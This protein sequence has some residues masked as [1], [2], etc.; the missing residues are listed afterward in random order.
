M[1]WTRFPARWAGLG[2]GLARWADPLGDGV[3]RGPGG[4]V[5]AGVGHVHPRFLAP[6]HGAFRRGGT[7]P[8]VVAA[9]DHWRPSGTPTGVGRGGGGGSP[10]ETVAVRAGSA[11]VASADC[12]MVRTSTKRSRSRVPVPRERATLCDADLRAWLKPR[13]AWHQMPAFSELVAELPVTP[14]GKLDR[15][16]LRDSGP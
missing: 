1:V 11:S 2:E 13:L 8:G 15:R 5:F 4:P 14:L 10:R 12:R 16:A 9:L 6:R 7:S 3:W